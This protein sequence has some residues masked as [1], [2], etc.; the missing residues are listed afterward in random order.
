M[1]FPQVRTTTA[2]VLTAVALCYYCKMQSSDYQCLKPM[3]FEMTYPETQQRQAFTGD[4]N[5]NI[6]VYIQHTNH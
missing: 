3:L 2:N 6:N 4:K 1:T 5:H